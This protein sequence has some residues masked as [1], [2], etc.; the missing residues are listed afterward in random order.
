MWECPDFFKLEDKWILITSPQDFIPQGL[1]FDNG[2]VTLGI[3]G[4][5][6][7]QTEKIKEQQI[8]LLDYGI[9]FYAPQTTLTP[10]GRRIMI[11][12]PVLI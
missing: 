11:E 8:Q 3:I 7:N 10:D 4:E 1:E 2:N 12:I 9:D 6:D 5:F